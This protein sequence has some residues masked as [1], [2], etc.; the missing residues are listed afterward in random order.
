MHRGPY[1]WSPDGQ[2]IVCE[3]FIAALGVW[4]PFAAVADGIDP[5]DP[6]DSALAE[7]IYRKRQSGT[8]KV[9]PADLE[10]LDVAPVT[11][12]QFRR[13]L[14]T[15]SDFRDAYDALG[16]ADRDELDYADNVSRFN[17]GFLAMLAVGEISDA[18]A[19]AFLS[20]C[21]TL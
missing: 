2:Y 11:P 21:A 17:P 10:P 19:D 7:D 15:Y 12:L 6:D 20:T 1:K 4:V 13:G 14:H 16:A 5:S 8:I 3:K 9:E 18:R